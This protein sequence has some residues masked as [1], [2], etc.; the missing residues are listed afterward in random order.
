MKRIIRASIGIG[1]TIA[2]IF[3]VERTMD[4]FGFFDNVNPTDTTDSVQIDEAQLALEKQEKQRKKVNNVLKGDDVLDLGNNGEVI[5]KKIYKKNTFAPNSYMTNFEYPK[6]SAFT[7]VGQ[8]IEVTFDLDEIESDKILFLALEG[9]DNSTDK[10]KVKYFKPR[11]GSNRLRLKT[12][13]S[14][15]SH[16]F[17]A[18]YCY[19]GDAK[20]R[21]I[22]FYHEAFD[23]TV[24]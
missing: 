23:V 3:L 22:R 9:Y 20:K 19:K 6:D 10:M 24:E 13:F 8:R 1:A 5:V 12:N 11:S 21:T 15:G 2:I 7:E 16:K 4:S 14:I 17:R 18:S